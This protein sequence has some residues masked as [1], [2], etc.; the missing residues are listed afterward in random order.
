[1]AGEERARAVYFVGPGRVETR[2]IPLTPPSGTVRVHSRLCGVSHGTEGLFFRGEAPRD[3]PGETLS[4]LQGELSYPVKYGYMNVGVTENGER[5]FAFYPHQDRFYLP[6]EEL[7]PLPD[8]LTFEDAVLLPTVETAV[9]IVH[10]LGP[11]LGETI[12]VTGLGMVGLLTAAILR[13]M[14]LTVFTVDPRPARRA[15][16]EALGCVALAGGGSDGAGGNDL[17]EP[18]KELRRRSGVDAFDGAVNT[19]GAAEALQLCLDS[20]APDGT[21]VEASWYGERRVTLALGGNFHRGR[22]HLRSA[23]VSTLNP[24]LTSR[25]SKE[26]RFR[27]AMDLAH[28]LNPGQYISHRFGFEQV[29]EAFEIIEHGAD[30]V[31]QVVLDPER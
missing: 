28:D 26:R 31:L 11:H 3:T 24:V 8:R 15:A 16:A 18:M 19:S 13:R 10:D 7:T 1:M 20:V 17:G 22:V 14:S 12:L 21:V 9:G 4:A 29:Q 23:Q 5:V 2:T 30:E 6:P 27:Y 25:W